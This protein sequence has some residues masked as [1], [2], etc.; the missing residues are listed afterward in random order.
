M[1]SGFGGNENSDRLG[2]G[3]AQH[4]LILTT[5]LTP[6]ALQIPYIYKKTTIVFFQKPSSMA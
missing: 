2:L 4:E 6:P 5:L 1:L 3:K